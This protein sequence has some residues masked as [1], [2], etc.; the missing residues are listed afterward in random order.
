MHGC[1]VSLLVWSIALTLRR[2]VLYVT[3]GGHQLETAHR[4][5]QTL[6]PCSA[7]LLYLPAWETLP[8]NDQTHDL[9]IVGHRLGVLAR[10]S[11]STIAK[12]PTV[13][14]SCIQAL[15]QKTTS[16]EVADDLQLS[17][18]I[19]QES[20]IDDI[21]TKLVDTGY[22]TGIEVVEKGHVSVRGGLVDIWPVDK[23][24]PVRIEFLGTAVESIRSFDPATQKS[25]D[26]LKSISILPATESPESTPLA[27]LPDNTV[28]VWSNIDTIRDHAEAYQ[29]IVSDSGASDVIVGLDA[30]L[31]EA[32]NRT[33]GMQVFFTDSVAAPIGNVGQDVSA[34]GGVFAV[35]RGGLQPDMAEEARR[36]LMSKASDH[37]RDGRTVVIFFDTQGSLDHF[38]EYWKPTTPQDRSDIHLQVGELSQGFESAALRLTIIAE[39]NLY[40]SRKQ[41]ETRYDP[42]K[43][44]RP[45]KNI[46]RR[47]GD[48]TDIEPGDLVV[49]LEHGIGRY[50]GL[51]EIE[52]NGQLREVLTLE[53]ADEAKLHVPVSHAHMLSRYVGVS[54][55]SVALHKLGGKR[56]GAQ[57]EEA[58]QS[59]VD[60]ASSLLDTQARRTLMP[61]HAFPPDAPWQ[62]AFEASFPYTETP[63]Q[64]DVIADVKADMESTR[65][66][67]RLICGD[68]GYG[69]TEIAMRAAFKAVM[70]GKQVAVLVPT[71]VL[72]QQ[73][74]QTFSERMIAYPLRIDMLSRF[75]TAGQRRD[76]LAA[77][78]DGSADIVIG[79]H[80]LIQQG[81][82]FN[83]LGLV[84]VDEEQ[85]FGVASKEYLKKAR[86]LVDVLTLSATPIPRTL[87]MSMTGARDMS[88]LQSPPRDRMAIETIVTKNT[89]EIV[90]KA[91]LT[92]LSRE[93]QVFY[94]HNRVLTI[95]MVKKHLTR[96][97]PEANIEIA[98]GQM[99]SSELAAVMKRFV[100][101][102]FDVLL[103]TTIIESGMDIPRTNTI[104][105]D[106]ADR[107]GI[108]DLYQLRGRVGRSNHKAY[109]Y[110]ML[111]SHGRIDADARKRIAAIK[112]FSGLSTGLNLALR[113]L[114]IRGA[115]NLLGAQQ[116]GHI[117][118]IGFSLYCQL[119][120]RSVATLKGED[121][122][123][124]ID[125]ELRIDFVSFSPNHASPA[126]AATI[127]YSFIEDER[128]RVEVY[129]RIAATTDTRETDALRDE[130]RDRFGILPPPVERL[131]KLAELRIV[132]SESCIQHI[133]VKNGKVMFT[134]D[135]EYIK[136]DA[137]FPRLSK[138]TVDA[139]L[140][141]LLELTRSARE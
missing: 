29:N 56:W 130:L 77:M 54:K 113:D 125:V 87:Y 69:K 64:H 2:T 53:Y 63:D 20:E 86:D 59:I 78:Q 36:K 102:E 95:E 80:A 116:S 110:L 30:L 131:L 45:P 14:C 15:M 92:E 101:G 117:T 13:L 93:G 22:R 19:D 124:I 66:M 132:A 25:I 62:H 40:G 84:I 34:I 32:D 16:P 23:A 126:T 26:R 129:R 1:A 12:S 27:W 58:R 119:L 85:R 4:D 33:G 31:M 72:A 42:S 68:A 137:R 3:D 91:I 55:H 73:H 136:Y 107:F 134:R 65:P 138:D 35:S 133:E 135:N 114:E 17:L 48:L 46:G 10:L 60:M 112:Q 122:P 74:Y 108:S 121:L 140:D 41:R 128:I 82:E 81:V 111:P 8:V 6:T 118:A 24:W 39:P 5:L 21:V 79:T 103:C 71:T 9:D 11:S 120:K 139:R 97:V 50:L 96:I 52:F 141:E 94:L 75:R 18:R 76:T 127:P 49:H 106:R 57:K 44:S 43:E 70:G 100:A 88:L 37:A 90:R 115:G 28:L 51:C 98:H 61:G 104:L 38:K 47:I 109:A 99:L 89:D 67:D 7:N 123:P 105:I 83:N